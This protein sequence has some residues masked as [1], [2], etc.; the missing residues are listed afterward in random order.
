VNYPLAPVSGVAKNPMLG[1]R[2]SDM[3]VVPVGKTL[4]ELAPDPEDGLL[5]VRLN[6]DNVY[7]PR[8]YWDY[9]VQYGD[10]V[11]WEVHYGSRDLLRPLL[12]IASGYRVDRVS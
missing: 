12:Q 1:I 5:V 3:Q 7:V 4:R 9:K 6:G 8:A 2:T 10:I 11:Q